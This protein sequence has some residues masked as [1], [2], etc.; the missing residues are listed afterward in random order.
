M[1]IE[2][3]DGVYLAVNDKNEAV[4]YIKK[5]CFGTH[6]HYR[7]WEHCILLGKRDD[8][9]PYVFSNIKEFKEYYEK[10]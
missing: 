10:R 5:N 2:K 6:G 4:A 9:A 8:D 7:G 1:K 3:L